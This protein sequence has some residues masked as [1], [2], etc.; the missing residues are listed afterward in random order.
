MKHEVEM[1]MQDNQSGGNWQKNVVVKKG[2]TL[3]IQPHDI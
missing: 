2:R 1:Q 3:T